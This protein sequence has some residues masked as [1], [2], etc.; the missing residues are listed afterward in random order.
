M[1]EGG[2][3]DPSNRQLL[4]GGKEKEAGSNLENA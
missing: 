2:C 1:K 4:K 3:E